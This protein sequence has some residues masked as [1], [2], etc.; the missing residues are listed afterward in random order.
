MCQT[1]DLRYSQIYQWQVV[2]TNGS[3]TAQHFV[4]LTFLR[5]RLTVE[6]TKTELV[7]ASSHHGKAH[8]ERT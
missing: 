8:L 4:L 3:D 2:H 7:K 5:K 1:E 6:D